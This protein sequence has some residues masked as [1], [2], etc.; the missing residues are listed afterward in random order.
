MI[1]L[2]NEVSSFGR[3]SLPKGALPLREEVL[4]IPGVL[5]V[6]QAPVGRVHLEPGGETLETAPAGDG[7]A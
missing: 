1:Q 3:A 7:G 6:V 2:L 5:A 4:P